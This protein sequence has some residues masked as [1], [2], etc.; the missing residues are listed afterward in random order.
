MF[1]VT[2]KAVFVAFRVMT[3]QDAPHAEELTS[4]MPSADA[5]RPTWT[6]RVMT[7]QYALHN[8]RSYE[9]MR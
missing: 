6:L 4:S 5:I 7:D 2:F 8:R 1:G 9:E 3:D